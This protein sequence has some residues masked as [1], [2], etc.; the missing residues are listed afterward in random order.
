MRPYS[1]SYTIAAV[2]TDGIVDGGTGAS[3]T[4]LATSSGD[5]LAHQLNFT[6]AQN[7]SD[8]TF[9]V[10]GTDENG[11]A[12]TEVVTGPNATTVESTKYFLTYE[13]ITPDATLDADTVDIGWVDEF[14]TP[15]YA[16]NRYADAMMIETDISGTINY[17]VQQTLIP[18]TEG[19][20]NLAWVDVGAGIAD[21]VDV[22]AITVDAQFSMNPPPSGIRVVAHSYSTGATLALRAT[23]NG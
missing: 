5:G 21:S 17:S 6:S 19:S 2:D 7:I 22:T 1:R 3:L 23:H 12:Q 8:H 9:T 14:V 18:M 20:A 13:S 10:V 16:C 15:T 4:L 11:A